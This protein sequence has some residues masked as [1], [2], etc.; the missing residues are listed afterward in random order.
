[1]STEEAKQQ[2]GVQT[3]GGIRHDHNQK[4][5]HDESKDEMHCCPERFVEILTENR[6]LADDGECDCVTAGGR[7]VEIKNGVVIIE[8]AGDQVERVV[9]GKGET[10]HHKVD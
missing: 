1:M 9:E 3:D 4:Q 8:N 5:H 6:G 7:F 10:E 2:K